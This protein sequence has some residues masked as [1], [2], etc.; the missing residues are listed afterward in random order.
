MGSPNLNVTGSSGVS[1]SASDQQSPVQ[2]GSLNNVSCRQGNP[3]ERYIKLKVACTREDIY[4]TFKID[5]IR[6]ADLLKE[7]RECFLSETE[8]DIALKLKIKD[9]EIFRVP[10][11]HFPEFFNDEYP[12]A[13]KRLK[14]VQKHDISRAH[15]TYFGKCDGIPERLNEL[16]EKIEQRDRAERKRKRF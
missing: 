4:P 16:S 3:K 11:E 13:K 6:D 9:V 2:T 14:F 5:W 10:D 7:Y 15:Q 12:D 8:I 1:Q